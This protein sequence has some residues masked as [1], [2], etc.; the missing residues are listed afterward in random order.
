MQAACY[1]AFEIKITDSYSLSR[2][3][4]NLHR[5]SGECHALS[6]VERSFQ[7]ILETRPVASW[8]QHLALE[9]CMFN[10]AHNVCNT[11]E[12][13]S[14]QGLFGLLPHIQPS[15]DSLSLTST[16]PGDSERERNHGWIIIIPGN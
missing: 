5:F 13:V 7:C 16:I 10:T 12:Q 3:E 14:V 2:V 4:K 8:K 9:R 11:N 6:D 15:R 1:Q